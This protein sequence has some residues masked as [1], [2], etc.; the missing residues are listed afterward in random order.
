[1]DH[2][3]LVVFA[4]SGGLIY[5]MAWPRSRSPIACWP[6][7]GPRFDKAARDIIDDEDEPWR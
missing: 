5:L 1:M 2:D 6:S 7:N 4:K 3:T